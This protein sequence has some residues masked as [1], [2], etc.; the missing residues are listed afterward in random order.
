MAGGTDT[1]GA[2][3]T[4]GMAAGGTAIIDSEFLVRMFDA[5]SQNTDMFDDRLER[6]FQSWLNP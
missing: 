6:R 4:A 5:L 1:G 3:D 2:Q